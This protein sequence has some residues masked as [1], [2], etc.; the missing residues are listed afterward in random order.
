MS[1]QGTTG[2]TQV[3]SPLSVTTA[4]G[5]SPGLI[6]LLSIWRDISKQNRTKFKNKQT[7]KRKQQEQNNRKGQSCHG[8]SQCPKEMPWPEG[9]TSGG[10]HYLA[11]ESSRLQTSV[12]THVHAHVHTKKGKEANPGEWRETLVSSSQNHTPGEWGDTDVLTQS[13]TPGEWGDTGVF[14]PKPHSWYSCWCL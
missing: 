1:S 11:E 10:E 3:Q 5:V 7:N 2:N 12:Y 8:S 14:T 9:W 6:I 4:T 13:Y